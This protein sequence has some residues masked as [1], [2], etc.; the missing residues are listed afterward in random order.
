[1]Q[2]FREEDFEDCDLEIQEDTAETSART[3]GYN[4]TKRKNRSFINVPESSAKEYHPLDPDKMNLSDAVT[5]FLHNFNPSNVLGSV[6][7][8]SGGRARLQRYSQDKEKKRRSQYS[9]EDTVYFPPSTS[10]CTNIELLTY[11]DID[12]PSFR[13][14]DSDEERSSDDKGS[15]EDAPPDEEYIHMHLASEKK[16][17]TRYYQAAVTQ[18]KK[19]KKTLIEPRVASPTWDGYIP[20]P[21]ESYKLDGIGWAIRDYPLEPKPKKDS[22]YKKKRK[23]K[24]WKSSKEG[25]GLRL[26]I[27]LK[28]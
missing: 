1:L 7:E 13:I 23:N 22:K 15:D 24:D 20:R 12:T 16:E 11:K 26:K 6:P 18:S 21:M 4:W 28:K 14:I 5:S 8:K 2:R 19:R 27:S 3:R 25:T 17:K 9:T 10:L